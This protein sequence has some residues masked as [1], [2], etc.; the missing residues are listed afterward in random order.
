MI[1]Y[2]RYITAGKPVRWTR[3]AR[4]AVLPGRDPADL[5]GDTLAL[6][7]AALRDT[8]NDLKGVLVAAI[9]RPLKSP[10]TLDTVTRH[11]ER[12]ATLLKAVLEPSRGLA[13]APPQALA[14][15]LERRHARPISSNVKRPEPLRAGPAAIHPDAARI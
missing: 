14:R 2:G 5:I 9:G 3:P 11:L 10:G 13:A 8:L 12:K 1:A 15:P 7:Q 6:T 4:G